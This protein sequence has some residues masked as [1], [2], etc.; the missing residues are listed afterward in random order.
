LQ[1]ERMRERIKARAKGPRGAPAAPTRS[2]KDRLELARA[3]CRDMAVTAVLTLGKGLAGKANAAQLKAADSILDRAGIP[4]RSE[5]EAAVDPGREL[6]AM[7]ARLPAAEPD[8]PD[9]DD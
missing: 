9:A 6:L 7:L 8:E 5:V 4:R 2:E 1:R 3:T